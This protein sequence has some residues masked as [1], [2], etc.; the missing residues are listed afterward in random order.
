[1]VVVAAMRKMQMG[2]IR[3]YCRVFRFGFDLFLVVIE[4][5]SWSMLVE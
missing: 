5:G 2:R 3:R 1:M 4:R